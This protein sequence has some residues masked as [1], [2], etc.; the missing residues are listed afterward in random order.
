[1]QR[2]S[3]QSDEGLH[4]KR[5]DGNDK[6]SFLAIAQTIMT[7]AEN[8]GC[9]LIVMSSRIQEAFDVPCVKPN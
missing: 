8:E 1:M 5:N 4:E 2:R 9:D 6:C 3:F 7:V